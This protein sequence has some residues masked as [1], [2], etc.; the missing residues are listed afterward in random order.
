MSVEILPNEQLRIDIRM[1]P[2]QAL[3]C[4][5]PTSIK[6]GF[7][8]GS[9]GSGKSYCLTLD[10]L[11]RQFH[12]HPRFTGILFRESYPE[13]EKSLIRE[14]AIWYPHFGATYNGSEHNWTFPSGAKIWFS[15]L[16]KDSQ[17]TQHDSAQYNYAAFDELTQFSRYRYMYIVHTRVR[18]AVEGLPAYSRSASNPLGIG[19]AWVKERFVEPAP[20]GGRII[21]ERMPDGKVVKRIFIKA[22]VQDNPILLKANPEYINSLMLLPE[23]ERRSK[24]YGDWDAIAG[25]V[26][27][28]FRQLHNADEPENAV[29]VIEPFIIPDHWPVIL[30]IDWGFDAMTW[31]GFF[32]VSPS[33]RVYLCQ[34]FSA[35]QTKISVWGADLARIAARY[36]GLRT[37]VTLDG[38]AWGNRGEEL[39][40]A[41]QIENAMGLPVEKA[42]RDRIGGKMLLHEYLRWRP[43]PKKYEPPDGYDPEIEQKIWRIR[44]D[45][46]AAD[47]RAYFMPEPDEVNLPQYQ[48]FNTCPLAIQALVAC[49]TDP[50]NP[51]DV[52]EW[53]G[54]DPY[55][56]QRYGLKRVH[57]YF[58]EAKQAGSLVGRRDDIV[59]RLH[60]TG[61]MTQFYQEME[62][63]ELL[64]AVTDGPVRRYSTLRSGRSYR[65]VHR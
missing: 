60:K 47:Y 2:K 55:D 56:G 53:D 15:Y 33:G 30:A 41:E 24:L 25:A 38:S 42:D 63:L 27:R 62:A 19:H 3:F 18:S 58:E 57:R 46:A 22:L 12:Q 37:P 65:S 54:D 48:I 39:T 13:L 5:I 31:A 4:S 6:E 26:F 7:Y 16:A 32:A 59:E 9:A 35:R 11:L 29:H 20:L 10:P 36:A 50:D 61:D 28:E 21:A 40:L 45:K 64:E 51:E 14:S 43:R 34:E 49:T 1:N 52:Q 23:A 8:G 44:G 17:V